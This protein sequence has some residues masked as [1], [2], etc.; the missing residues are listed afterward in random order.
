MFRDASA[1]SYPVNFKWALLWWLPMFCQKSRFGPKQ[2]LQAT[3]CPCETEQRQVP[4]TETCAWFTI[5]AYLLCETCVSTNMFGTLSLIICYLW[6]WWLSPLIANHSKTSTEDSVNPLHPAASAYF[7]MTKRLN[8]FV[9]YSSTFYLIIPCS[10]QVWRTS[11]L[12]CS[13][14]GLRWCGSLARLYSTYFTMPKMKNHVKMII[15][16]N[17]AH[18]IPIAVSVTIIKVSYF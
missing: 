10:H 2:M 3:V 1:S 9:D 8:V 6:W 11:T 5:T 15:L 7:H 12:C 17:T 18:H 14:T 4:C 16:P 13:Q